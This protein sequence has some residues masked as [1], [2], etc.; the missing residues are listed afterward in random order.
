MNFSNKLEE[1]S[2]ASSESGSLDEKWPL[3]C[4]GAAN[5]YLVICGPSPG[6]SSDPAKVNAGGANRPRGGI[7]KYGPGSFDISSW[8]GSRVERWNK[9]CASLL[10]GEE[11][12][13]DRMTAVLNL[14][15]GNNP[16]TS[17]NPIP[18]SVLQPGFDDHVWE[19]IK[20]V[21]PRVITALTNSVWDVM[22][23]KMEEHS[24]SFSEPPVKLTRK[25][26][27]LQLPDTGF[28]SMFLKTQ[29]HP[30]RS[31]FTDA[32]ISELGRL[33]KWFESEANK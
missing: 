28:V 22:K 14:D 10:C 11:K 27:F 7:K 4:F 25:P 15:W 19:E 32:H 3:G 33:A 31:Y 29:N 24:V 17:K 1:R 8:G 20:K 16:D 12:H 21:K 13:I 18:K 2:L 6:G 5:A 9:L 30:S 23:N 26:I